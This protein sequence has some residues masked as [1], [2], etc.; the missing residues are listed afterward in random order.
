MDI[1]FSNPYLF[2]EGTLNLLH[3]YGSTLLDHVMVWTTRMGGQLFF[4][5]AI[6]VLYWCYDKKLAV[7]IG[8]IY[9]LAAFVNTEVKSLFNNPRPDPAKLSQPIRDLYHAYAPKS[10]GFPSGH[11]QGTVAFWGSASYYIP[12]RAVWITGAILMILV[13][14][15]RMYLGVHYAGDVLGGYVLGMLCLALFIPLVNSVEKNMVVLSRIAAIMVINIT[16]WGLHIVLPEM[17]LLRITG[18]AAGLATGIVLGRGTLEFHVKNVLLA[19]LTKTVIGIGG[20]VLIYACMKA[21]LRFNYAPFARYWSI[22]IWITI[23]A[24]FIFSRVPF[25]SGST[26]ERS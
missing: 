21:M 5:I 13:P 1:F 17:S 25:L 9:L 19:H 3:I 23:G 12:R 8:S 26:A 6:P 20:I 14:Y 2:G 18:I 4:I 22:G 7:R 15:S 11:T 24:P 10:P 16:P